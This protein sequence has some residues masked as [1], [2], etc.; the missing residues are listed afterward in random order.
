[1]KYI[2]DFLNDTADAD[3]TKWL[4]DNTVTTVEIIE[5]TGKVYLID[6]AVTPN[7]TSIVETITLD[8][9]I[10]SQLLGT[11]EIIPLSTGTTS[12]F[13]HEADWWK[14]ASCANVDFVAETTTFESRGAASTVYILD[15]GIDKAHVDLVNTKIVDLFSF[16]EVNADTSG[17]GTAL[18]S[19]VAGQTCGITNST[20]K[21]V[22]IFDKTT[23]TMLSDIVKALDAV[24]ADIVANQNSISV[25][26]MSW[27]I[28]KNDYVETKLQRLI[29]VGAILVA[30]AGNSGVAIENVT[31]ASMDAV[32]T[33]G[34]YDVN[35]APAD[36]SN[37]TSS[38]STTPNTTNY[39]ALDVWAPGVDIKAALL[40]GTMGNI[41]GTSA[42]AA[43]MTACLAYNSDM[44]YTKTGPSPKAA[45]LMELNS[46]SKHGLLVLSD[47]YA[48]SVNVAATFRPHPTPTMEF[49]TS[50]I[51]N[52]IYAGVNNAVYIAPNTLVSKIELSIDLP[53]GLS[54]SNGWIVGT[55]TTSPTDKTD[56]LQFTASVTYTT[57][58]VNDYTVRL[59]MLTPDVAFGDHPVDITLL[60]YCTGSSGSCYGLCEA[61]C[62]SCS[63]GEPC[64]SCGADCP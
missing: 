21:N 49:G 3:I 64:L 26:N 41:S 53:D 10:S 30:A 37:Y 47:K 45:I 48:S 4:A 19:I 20:I 23:E 2:V 60:E 5:T 29:D 1:M 14:T 52:L 11:V 38:V 8:V 54:L 61:A 24:L 9:N 62:N 31:P 32:L 25:V 42:A 39:G 15:S 56:L 12:S 46:M 33:V 44:S 50:T 35:F 13:D 43:V 27:S 17:H 6:T 55:P 7:P 22:K 28:P 58:S 34:A 36:F 40:D 57:G 18:A 51:T 63:K 59:Y 16:T